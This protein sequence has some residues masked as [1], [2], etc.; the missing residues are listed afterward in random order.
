MI[1]V[2]RR[3]QKS[4]W[5]SFVERALGGQAADEDARAGEQVAGDSG[6]PDRSQPPSQSLTDEQEDNPARFLAA[7]RAGLEEGDSAVDFDRRRR[8]VSVAGPDVEERTDLMAAEVDPGEPEM[9]V[10]DR[11]DPDQRDPDRDAALATAA[12]EEPTPTSA[13]RVD[14]APAEETVVAAEPEA[15][16]S[17]WAD[18]APE[19]SELRAHAA[20]RTETPV[21]VS[22]AQPPHLFDEDQTP[23]TATDTGQAAR[24]GD[25][26]PVVVDFHEQRARFSGLPLDNSEYEDIEDQRIGLEREIP[27]MAYEPTSEPT[28][29]QREAPRSAAPSPEPEQDTAATEGRSRRL[30][31]FVAF[32][33]ANRT[34]EDRLRAIAEEVLV[35]RAAFSSLGPLLERFEQDIQVADSIEKERDQL[36]DRASELMTTV[37]SIRRDLEIKSAA[38]AALVA[39]N[40]ELSIEIDRRR[41]DSLEMAAKNERLMKDVDRFEG[42]LARAKGEIVRLNGAL[43]RETAEVRAL[44]HS[45]SELSNA[46]SK[47]QQQEAIQRHKLVEMRTQHET[48]LAAQPNL[49]SEQEKLRN[50][51]RVAFREKSEL[52]NQILSLQDK[53]NVLDAEVQSIQK[54][55]AAETY[56]ARMETDLQRSSLRTAEK[57]I[58]EAEQARAQLERKLRD[59]EN[60]R[61]AAE[62]KARL[63]QQE[64]DQVR[65]EQS[66]ASFRLSDVNLKHMTDLIS[67]DQQREYNK[68][69]Q[70]GF[71]SLMAEKRRLEKFEALYKA[72]E[73]Q[74]ATLTQRLTEAVGKAEA[75]A[76]AEEQAEAEAVETT[77][78]DETEQAPAPRKTASGA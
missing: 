61:L 35:S 50:E 23:A 19:S 45:R 67:L 54:H 57:S 21:E 73:R 69:I 42:E 33:E 10:G 20:D 75:E 48:L 27:A 4:G 55:A 60:A 37:E 53:V 8:D 52:Q 14:L 5:R 62:E 12:D 17:L 49:V 39:R 66:N 32:R 26:K 13:D 65:Q 77:T 70:S 34:L 63:V 11:R 44:Y 7:L 46:L 38:H 18:A 47:L 29:P 74:V 41:A 22:M 76:D 25:A 43:E 36:A 15:P 51:L 16:P 31:E 71:E 6:A 64:L 59:A 40:G 24:G 9:F 72:A 58:A 56:S 1:N 78:S 68:E 2:L 28:E 3:K 30:L